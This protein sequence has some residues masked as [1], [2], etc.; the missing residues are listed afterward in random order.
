MQ[1]GWGGK[2][3]RVQ[4]VFSSI[5]HRYDL[6]NTLMTFG[7]HRRWRRA[8]IRLA[9]GM[10]EGGQG[11]DLGCGTGDFLHEMLVSSANTAVVTGVDFT[12]EMLAVAQQ[13]FAPEIERGQVKLVTGDAS[14]LSFLPEDRFGMVTAGFTLRNLADLPRALGEAHRV[15][16]PGGA[17]VSVE[18]CRPFPVWLRPLAELYLRLAVPVLAALV[19]GKLGEYRWLHES[20]ATCP[21]RYELA[22]MLKAAGFTEV[23]QVPFGLGVVVAHLAQKPC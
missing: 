17:F 6:L 16:K 5:A 22:G 14:D 4:R 8:S 20:L 13:R 2:P 9:G 1:E 15:M 10:L 12:A 18:V 21:D 11:L 7:L 23:R 19:S 3:Q